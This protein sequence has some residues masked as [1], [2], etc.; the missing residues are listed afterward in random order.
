MKRSEFELLVTQALTD[1]PIE[2]KNRMENV[3]GVVEEE[4]SKDQIAGTFIG[5]EESL[6]AI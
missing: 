4:P 1:K 6:V 3:E 5:D 2:I